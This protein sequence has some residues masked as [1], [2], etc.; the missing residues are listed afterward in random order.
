MA[1]D[2]F[3]NPDVERLVEEWH[4]KYGRLI[5]KT[6]IFVDLEGKT[7]EEIVSTLK[8]TAREMEGYEKTYNKWK[9][10]P[11]TFPL[12]LVARLFNKEFK[13]LYELSKCRHLIL[14]EIEKIRMQ[15]K[16]NGDLRRIT[17][18]KIMQEFRDI[19]P[20]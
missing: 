18:N 4:E 12:W 17:V 10:S 8:M 3:L 20:L 7:E 19:E 15:K 1:G 2:V 9:W 6:P 14:R 16:E 13:E 5:H 11:L